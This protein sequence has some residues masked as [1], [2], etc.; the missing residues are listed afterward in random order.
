MVEAVAIFRALDM[1]LDYLFDT[2]MSK[3]YA[4][5]ALV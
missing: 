4:I 3:C 5:I 2:Q 1:L